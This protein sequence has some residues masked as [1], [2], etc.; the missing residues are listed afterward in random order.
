MNTTSSVSGNDFVLPKFSK[1]NRKSQVKG[2][3]IH[4]RSDIKNNVAFIQ[5]QVKNIAENSDRPT[6]KL[7]PPLKKIMIDSFCCICHIVMTLPIIYTTCCNYLLGC[8]DCVDN[9]YTSSEPD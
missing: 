2:G 3:E 8:K 5:A 9:W 6:Q 1:I 4:M 7:T